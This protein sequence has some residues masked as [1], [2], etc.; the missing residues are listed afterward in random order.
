MKLRYV[1][2]VI[3]CLPAVALGSPEILLDKNLNGLDIRTWVVE[4]EEASGSINP[5]NLKH[6]RLTNNHSS[7]VHCSLR[8]EP[9]EDSWT[10]FPDAN[11]QP[12]AKAELPIGGDYSTETIRVKLTCEDN[13]LL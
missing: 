3:G 9:A 10:F 7:A 4:P 5:D 6:L 11:I 1:C 2:A 12:G 13:D 8:P